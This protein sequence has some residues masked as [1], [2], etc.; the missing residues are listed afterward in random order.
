MGDSLPIKIYK[1][2][3]EGGEFVESKYGDNFFTLM[4]P[5]IEELPVLDIKAEVQTVGE[6]RSILDPNLL[7]KEQILLDEIE[8]T[9]TMRNHESKGILFTG[10][11]FGKIRSFLGI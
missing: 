6:M 10:I 7:K 8:L 5:K 11:N 1:D 4:K 2:V 3:F 9:K